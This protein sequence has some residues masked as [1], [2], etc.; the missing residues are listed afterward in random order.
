MRIA[1]LGGSFNPIHLGHALLADTVKI[2]LGYDKII[3]VPAGNPPHKKLN[4]S[5]SCEERFNMVKNFCDSTDCF[6]AEPFEIQKSGL[7]YTYDT[8][9]FILE[10]YSSSLD[11]KPGLIMGEEVACEFHKWHKASQIAS[12]TDLIIARRHPDNNGINIAE[13]KNQNIGGYEGGFSSFDFEKDFAFPFIMLENPL[14]PVSSTEI[15]ARISQG[16]SFRY[17]VPPE[18]YLYIKQKG[19]YQK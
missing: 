1:I 14:L 17:L 16:K 19:L 13:F 12:L 9:K 8:V 6:C 15:R 7:S 2:D 4:G 5:V 11:G 18:V 10:K 3:F